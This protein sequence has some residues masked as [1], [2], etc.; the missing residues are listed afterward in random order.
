ME[1]FLT[2]QSQRSCRIV[3]NVQNIHLLESNTASFET[4][5]SIHAKGPTECLLSQSQATA[6]NSGLIICDADLDQPTYAEPSYFVAC[7]GFALTRF[8]QSAFN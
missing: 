6:V 5:M 1:K 7:E 8:A 3:L 2:G 4:P